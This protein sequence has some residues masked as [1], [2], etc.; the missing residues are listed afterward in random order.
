MEKTLTISIAAYNVQDT[1]ER[2]LDSLLDWRINDDIEIIV[3]DDG[4]QDES[5][6]IAK[7]YAEE[8]P[9]IVIPVHKEN[10]G[11]GSTIN[12]SLEKSTGK[13]FKQLDGDDWFLTEN[14][15][16]F[17][18]VLK[19]T[20]AD[21]VISEVAEYHAGTGEQKEN[22]VHKKISEGI[23]SFAKINFE[24]VLTMHGTAIKTKILQDHNIRIIEKCF[25]SDTEL[26]V[27][28]MPYL[29]T[30][31]MFKKAVYVYFIGAE[32]QSMSLGGIEKHYPDHEKVYWELVEVYN[33]I[34]EENTNK[35][36][37]ILMR[38]AKEA[39]FH[40]EFLCCLPI[41]STHKKELVEFGNRLKKDYPDVYEATRKRR[42]MVR[43]LFDTKFLAYHLVARKTRAKYKNR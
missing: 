36:N 11:Y 16:E 34:P 6:S 13:Y 1:I 39:V 24:S 31:Y 21:C 37:I 8:Y 18:E 38:L 30:F 28:P 22:E 2:A 33:M 19:K 23:H 35:R 10:G 12:A 25:Y 9:G 17:V 26:V 27:L 4:G 40:I 5:L 3:V 41:S 14:F 20:E 15:V 42:R 29:E 43:I 32:G 7:R